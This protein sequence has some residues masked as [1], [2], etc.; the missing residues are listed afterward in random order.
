MVRYTLAV[1]VGVADGCRLGATR[2]AAL[3]LWSLALPTGL[4][5]LAFAMGFAAE[6]GGGG[7]S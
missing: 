2:E 6:P 1:I 4:A 7:R 3:G 5:M